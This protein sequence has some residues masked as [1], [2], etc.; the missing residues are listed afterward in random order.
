MRR[1][2]FCDEKVYYYFRQHYYSAKQKHP[3]V[4]CCENE[5]VAEQNSKVFRSVQAVLEK[6]ENA[7]FL[8][9]PFTLIVTKT[10]LFT[11]EIWQRWL[12]V[13]VN[14]VK[15]TFSKT[16]TWQL[17]CD[18][19]DRGFLKHNFKLPPGK[20][21]DSISEWYLRFQ[22]HPRPKSVQGCT[23]PVQIEFGNAGRIL[24][25]YSCCISSQACLDTSEYFVFA[26]WTN[27]HQ[28]QFMA[29]SFKLHILLVF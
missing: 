6:F 11:G 25:G 18:F 14:I 9:I 19:L 20:S 15:K 3:W 22:I 28:L 27:C 26:A 21:F 8:G 12:S 24:I 10:K 23:N 4:H 2:R 16:T 29:W 1:E 13:D 5:I 17:S 7:V